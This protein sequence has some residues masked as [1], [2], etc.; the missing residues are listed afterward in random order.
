MTDDIIAMARP[1]NDLMEKYNIIEQFKR[2][3]FINCPAV[4]YSCMSDLHIKRV[5]E[6]ITFEIEAVVVPLI[7]LISSRLNIRSVINMQIPGEHAHCGPPQDPECG[8]T[9]SPQILMDND[10]ESLHSFTD[11]II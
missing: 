9:Y 1:S 6:N 5:E 4:M 11:L 8:F 2:Y 3:L 10:S 7:F